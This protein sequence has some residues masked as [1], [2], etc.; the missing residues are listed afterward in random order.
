M[1]NAYSLFLR[2]L[3]FMW[4][5]LLIPFR[6]RKSK[7]EDSRNRWVALARVKKTPLIL[8]HWY[9]L[10]EGLNESPQQFYRSLEQIVRRR[11]LPDTEL[12][13]IHR[14]EGG[15]LSAKREYVRVSRRD[16]VFEICAAPFGNG[17]F[18][19][20]RLHLRPG[21]F[22][23]LMIRV[24][25][26]GITLFTIFRPPTSYW[27]DTGLVFQESV[28]SAV[29]EVLDAITNVQGLRSLAGTERKPILN[30]LFSA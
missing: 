9:H 6:R 7:H 27:L 20:W 19:S 30:Q 3:R 17:F 13:R 4:R 28:H 18:I 1:F 29:L 23:R 21:I 12:S 10:V 14:Y 25:G 11:N 24:P 5:L 22:W 26:V 16:R 8:S 2:L 15:I